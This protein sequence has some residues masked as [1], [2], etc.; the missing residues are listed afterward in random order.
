MPVNPMLV[1]RTVLLII[2][3]QKGG[4]LDGYNGGIP[5]MAAWRAHMRN[6]RRLIDA[7][8]AAGH[9]IIFFQEAHRP[10]HVDFGRELDGTEDVHCVEGAEG[11]E[12]AV[13][14][15]DFRPSD[16]FI[17]KRRYSCFFGTD[18]EILL[19]GLKAETLVLVGGLT[20][21]CVHYTYADAH[22]HD[23]HARVISDAV[24]G[25]SEAAHTASLAAM[26]YLQTGAVRTTDAMIAA[27]ATRA[28][29]VSGVG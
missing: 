14:E 9:P 1:G 18:L 16:Y 27:F 24:A 3:I 26:E 17:R 6:A 25:S 13:E 21:V 11:T 2:D 28:K 15:I 12:L 8:R 7:A 29:A 20:D 19:K 10:D 4:F 23:Y 22:Q 5:K